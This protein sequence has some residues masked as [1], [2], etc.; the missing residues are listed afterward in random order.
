MIVLFLL[1]LIQF[2]VACACLAVNAEQQQAITRTGWQKAAN[3]TKTQVQD[4]L[5]CC[6]F[7]KE[8]QLVF[9]GNESDSQPGLGH[10]SCLTVSFNP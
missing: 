1:F 3:Q 4:Y 9:S 7:T 5:N 8:L 10:P 6:G 2:A